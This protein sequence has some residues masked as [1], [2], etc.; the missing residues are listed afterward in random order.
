MVLITYVSLVTPLYSGDARECGAGCEE[1]ELDEVNGY[2]AKRR[3]PC[4]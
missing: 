1:G 2:Q 3:L 4:F